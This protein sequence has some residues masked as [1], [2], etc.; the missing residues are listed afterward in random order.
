MWYGILIA[1]SGGVSGFAVAMYYRWKS[2]TKD[3][4]IVG[5]NADVRSLKRDLSDSDKVNRANVD[6]AIKASAE[7]ADNH[8]RMN[9]LLEDA[10][11]ERDKYMAALKVVRASHP[12]ALAA[13]LGSLFPAPDK[14]GNQGGSRGGTRTP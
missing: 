7:Y 11:A 8:A 14:D 3:A 5:L 1:I 12:G 6:A 4:T 10:R 13:D 2:A 9:K